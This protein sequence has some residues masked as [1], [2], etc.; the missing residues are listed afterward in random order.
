MADNWI[1]SQEVDLQRGVQAPQVWPNALVVCGD[2]KAHTWR[3][4][5]M[6]D[7]SPA[8]LSGTVTGY[9]I[10]G[11]DATVYELGLAPIPGTTVQGYF[12]VQMTADER[13]ARRGGY[14]VNTSYAGVAF[15]YCNNQ[16]SNAFSYFGARPR[17]R[18]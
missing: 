17:S 9:F 4:T 6:D 11:D 1:L 10:R 18:V 13:V 12:Y 3:V 5:I 14:Y 16:R 2:N 8:A 7:G 15:L